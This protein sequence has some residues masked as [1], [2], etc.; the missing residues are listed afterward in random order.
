MSALEDSYDRVADEYVRRIYGEL[1]HKPL[2]QQLLDQFASQVRG[3]GLVCD[4]GCG[5]GHVARYLHERGVPVCGVDLAPEMV[6][7]ARELNPGIDFQVG[8]MR[9]L[10][11][12]DGAWAAIVAFYS[13][14][15]IPRAEVVAVLREFFRALAPGGLLLLGFHIGSD[16]LH[17]EELWNQQVSM[18]F[19]FFRT[20][21]MAGYLNS[22]G[23]EVEQ[24]VERDPYPDL[25]HPS[26]RGYIRACKPK[27]K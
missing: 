13:I 11:V 15:H 3:V 27:E 25:E 23:L 10:D 1:E 4:L 18:D 14:I 2:D 6:K 16:V 8:D 26:R 5:P 22:A 12:P 24:I 21:E 7:R 19:Y 17:L 9:R 20:E